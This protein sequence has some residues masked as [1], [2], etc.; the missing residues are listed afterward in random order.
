[1]VKRN[2][3]ELNITQ[4]PDEIKDFAT[5]LEDGCKGICSYWCFDYLKHGPTK[6][7]LT[8][9]LGFL[10]NRTL[11]AVEQWLVSIFGNIKDKNLSVKRVYQDPFAHDYFMR[12]VYGKQGLYM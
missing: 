12:K 3:F 5:L 1:M 9:R 4:H 10:T 11:E 7:T 8:V 2:R 6:T